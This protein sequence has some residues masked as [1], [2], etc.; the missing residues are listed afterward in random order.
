M[1]EIVA[2]CD[3]GAKPKICYGSFLVFKDG[4]VTSLSRLVF[5]DGT[6]NQAEYFALISLLGYLVAA[7]YKNATIRMDSQLVINHVTDVWLPMPDSHLAV[8]KDEAEALLK[9]LDKIK[10]EHIS[11]KTM[12]KILGH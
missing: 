11:D 1:G 8:L 5:R 6:N 10:F 9:K 4:E 7:G 12:K 3:G 2:Y